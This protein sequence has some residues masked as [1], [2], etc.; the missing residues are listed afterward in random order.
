MVS[1]SYILDRYVTFNKYA[2]FQEYWLGKRR[3]LSLGYLIDQ[4]TRSDVDEYSREDMSRILLEK[5]IAYVRNMA[6]SRGLQPEKAIELFDHGRPF[7]EF[8]LRQPGSLSYT[9]RSLE[10]CIAE[11]F[12][13][14]V[15]V[16]DGRYVFVQEPG[17]FDPDGPE[18]GESSG[19]RG[20]VGR[21]LV[22]MDSCL[23]IDADDLGFT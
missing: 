16:I 13:R 8:S 19:S 3:D 15:R 1:F 17:W 23:I 14:S 5:G 2:D 10:C 18:K 9:L 12:K 22:E 11:Y 20:E 7:Q 6:E 4:Y 21:E